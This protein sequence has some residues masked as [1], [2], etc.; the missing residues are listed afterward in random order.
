MSLVIAQDLSLAYGSKILLEED[1]FTIGPQDRVG[2]VGANGTGKSTLLKILA[3]K[4]QPDGGS[5]VFRRQARVGYLPQDLAAAPQGN[6]L[7]AVLAAVPGRESLEARLATTEEAL[8][9]AS[10]EAEQLELAATLAELHEELEHFEEHY[11]RHRAERILEGLGFDASRFDQPTASLSGGWRMR[12]ALAALLLQDPDLLLLDEPTNHLDIPTLTWFDGFLRR[13]RKAMVL[14]SHDRDF[15]DRQIDRVLSLEIEGLRSYPGNYE[16]YKVQRAEEAKLLEA[17]A[18]NLEAKRAHLQAFVDRFRY[19][20]TKARQAQSRLKALE[21]LDTVQ[22]LEERATMRFRF[23]EVQRSGREVVKFEGLRKA[24]GDNVVYDGASAAIERGQRISIVAPNGA[25]KTTL[26]KMLAG[27]LQPDGGT[28]SF[29]HNVIMG[30]YAQHHADTLDPRA[31]ILGFVRELVPQKGEREVRSILGALMFSGDDVD[32][33]I[34]V[35]SGGERARV[36]LARLLVLPSNLLFMDEPTNHLDLD[37][38][39]MLIEALKEYEGTLVFVSHNRSFINGLATHVWEVKDRGVLPHIGNLDDW[40]AHQVPP[41]QEA[42]RATPEAKTSLGEKERRRLEAEERQRRSAVEGPIKREIEECE[43]RIAA[44]EK[45]IAE[46]AAQLAD[47]AL[48]EDFARAKPLMD[49]HRDAKEEL[50]GL[51][52]TWEE[53]QERLA[54]VQS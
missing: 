33:K 30:Y 29:G 51:Y 11:G 40:L 9:Q 53:A 10:E 39:E 17:Q 43:R 48:Y 5:L 38:S 6:L 45:T 18:E 35:L 7:E 12:A 28:I 22:L 54:A 27:E 49:A 36:A 26:L 25:G 14:I 19:K 32:K 34:G 2:L 23:P 1:G 41:E 15:L 47:P 16:R 42:A 31:T 24:F 20:A 4:L 52:A 13:S 44:L 37:S 46:Q 3:G 8:A 50:D 21:K